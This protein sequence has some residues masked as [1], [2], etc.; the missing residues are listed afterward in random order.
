[1]SQRGVLPAQQQHSTQQK[2]N[3]NEFQYP[4]RQGRED[5]QYA[6]AL[7]I[8]LLRSGILL[9]EVFLLLANE[10][11]PDAVKPCMDK[12]H[13]SLLGIGALS[14]VFANPAAAAAKD[15]HSGQTG[16]ADHQDAGQG[17]HAA[18]CYQ[19]GGHYQQLG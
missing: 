9:D 15:G 7:H 11:V 17:G 13:G 2:T 5:R 18:N 19:Q 14:A 16:D 10:D 1:M 6:L 3:A 12:L 8:A 4:R